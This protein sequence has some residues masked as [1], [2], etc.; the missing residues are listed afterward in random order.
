MER[1]H[2]TGPVM[3]PL[4]IQFLLFTLVGWVSR[5]QLEPHRVSESRESGP[6]RAA[7][8]KAASFHGRSASASRAQGETTRKTTTPRALADRHPG[9]VASLVPGAERRFDRASLQARWA[10]SVLSQSRVELGSVLAQYAVGLDRGSP[11]FWAPMRI[12]ICQNPFA[13][14]SLSTRSTWETRLNG[15]REAEN[16]NP[17]CPRFRP[18]PCDGLV[19]LQHHA[20]RP[21]A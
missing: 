20:A 1:R 11:G 18:D 5:Q 13:L 17:F 12:E 2:A 6:P 7:R 15:I 14:D 9:Y 21:D 8:R 3:V 4:P 19:R 16:S 10:S